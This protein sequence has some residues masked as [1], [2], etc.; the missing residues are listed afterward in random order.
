DSVVHFERILQALCECELSM[1][2]S[3]QTLR[4]AAKEMANYERL[5][6]QTGESIVDCR[7]RLAKARDELRTA[8]R[9]RE[10]RHEYESMAT[11]INRHCDRSETTKKLREL[12]KEIQRIHSIRDDLNKRLDSRRQQFQVMLGA[13]RQ[14]NLFLSEDNDHSMDEQEVDVE[15]DLIDDISDVDMD[16]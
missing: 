2:K 3:A 13:S 11:L 8:K 9:V 5:Y 1:S 15:S 16:V 14:L 12:R 4:M 10:Y 6:E 7:Q